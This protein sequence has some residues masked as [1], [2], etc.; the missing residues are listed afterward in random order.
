MNLHTNRGHIINYNKSFLS[1]TTPTARLTYRFA[2]IHVATV[3]DSYLA[4]LIFLLR[5]AARQRRDA[6]VHNNALLDPGSATQQPHFPGQHYGNGA[7]ADDEH[8]EYGD[9]GRHALAESA[10]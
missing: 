10:R 1:L 7:K 9:H 2:N 3:L 5:R 8:R 6:F 4:L